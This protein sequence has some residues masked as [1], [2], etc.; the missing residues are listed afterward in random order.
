MPGITPALNL[1]Q[2]KRKGLTWDMGGIRAP[3]YTPTQVMLEAQPLKFDP[4]APL[5][6][7]TAQAGDGA[8]VFGL[9]MQEVY[10]ESGLDRLKGYFFPN[11]TRQPLRQGVKIGVITGHGFV[12]VTNIEGVVSANTQ[13]YFNPTTGMLMA[14]GTSGNQISAMFRE[15]ADNTANNLTTGVLIE[16]MFP[17]VTA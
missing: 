4:S 13:V 2:L 5:Q 12:R 1:P 16:H 11:D 14:N 6:V 10:D 15:S 7:L 17:L 8:K 9:A 3:Y